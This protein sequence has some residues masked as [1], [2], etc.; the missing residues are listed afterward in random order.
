MRTVRDR[1][2]GWRQAARSI[3][4]PWLPPALAGDRRLVRRVACRTAAA[5]RESQ[6]KPVEV[7]IAN[8][9]THGCAVKSEGPQEVGARC[10]VI[11]PTL[12]SWDAT[13]AW[14]RGGLLGLAFSRPLHRSVAEMIVRRSNGEL[15]WSAPR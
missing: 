14:A 10:W 1:A 6:R 5:F 4:D 11:L 3:P 13:V 12:E 7:R 9:S 8:L 15:P 2:I